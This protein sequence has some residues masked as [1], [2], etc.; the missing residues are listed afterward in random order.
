MSY[1]HDL[2]EILSDVT[3]ASYFDVK[4][5]ED[6]IRAYMIGYIRRG[7]SMRTV[8]T[9]YVDLIRFA[10]DLAHA[11]NN[12]QPM[13]VERVTRHVIEA[14]LARLAA[15]LEI[16]CTK[17]PSLH[18]AERRRRIVKAFLRWLV[19]E[20]YLD[21]DPTKKLSPIPLRKRFPSD[22]SLHEVKRFLAT[23]DKTALLGH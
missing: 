20:E 9:S 14:H 3:K 16:K 8:F 5:I 21:R 13:P 22:W 17:Q 11:D 10:Q 1:T 19:S 18:T 2:A 23:F 12:N 7:C 4:T 15:G 6:G